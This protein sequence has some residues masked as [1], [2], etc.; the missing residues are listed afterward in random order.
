MT[1]Q[2]ASASESVQ[3]GRSSQTVSSRRTRWPNPWGTG[4]MRDQI[5]FGYALLTVILI[6]SLLLVINYSFSQ[7]IDRSISENAVQLAANTS[8]IIDSTIERMDLAAKQVLFSDTIIEHFMDNRNPGDLFTQLS[9]RRV[10]ANELNAI[11]GPSYPFVEQVN[12]INCSSGIY[13]GR[14]RYPLDTMISLTELDESPLVRSTLIRNGELNLVQPHVDTWSGNSGSV[15][16]SVTRAI[17]NPIDATQRAIVEVPASVDRIRQLVDESIRESRNVQ[18]TIIFAG[19]GTPVLRMNVADDSVGPYWDALVAAMQQGAAS[20]SRGDERYAYHTSPYT[21]WTLLLAIDRNAAATPLASLRLQIILLLLLSIPATLLMSYAISNRFTRPIK[22]I[23]Q[24]IRDISS[25]TSIRLNLD[26]AK[27]R[28]P[29]NELDEL[30][31]AFKD[32]ARQLE[33]AIAE[34]VSARSYEM[35]ATMQALESRMNPHFLYNTIAMIKVIAEQEGNHDI[36]EI[37]MEMSS[38]LRYILAKDMAV[39]TIESE[40]IIATNYLNLMYRRFHDRLAFNV[41]IPQ[42][43][44]GIPV[45]RMIVQPIIENCFKH[46][47]QGQEEWQVSLLGDYADGTWRLEVRDNGSGFD[48]ERMAGLRKHM[49]SMSVNDTVTS[50]SREGIGLVNIYMRLKL[51]YGENTIFELDSGPSGGSVITIGARNQPM[52]G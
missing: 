40:L 28:S 12:L 31:L 49:A 46:G 11:I 48:P 10:I 8:A 26:P 52:P 39:A 3:R 44:L 41:K 23:N 17:K 18:K 38:I 4:R 29:M 42:E 32:L 22:E 45:P 16:F 7:Q 34:T 6:L 51:T 24:S 47:F 37:C 50:D 21:G 25:S 20:F 35:Q 36:V 30:N 13:I 15:V 43:M 27:K 33:Q 5:F 14:G 2:Q 9:N 19:A 1:A